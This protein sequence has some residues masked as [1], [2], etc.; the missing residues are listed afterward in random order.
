M[1]DTIV[2]FFQNPTL[3]G[4]MALIALGVFLIIRSN[5]K[6]NMSILQN[7]MELLKETQA[8][9]SCIVNM[10]EKNKT[11]E[12]RF[13]KVLAMYES[14]MTKVTATQDKIASTLEVLVSKQDE[15]SKGLQKLQVDLVRIQVNNKNNS[16]WGCE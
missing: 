4:L 2:A 12:D 13:D 6:N 8:N 15:C 9:Y 11:E 10:L 1:T 16:G 3:L 7:N 5:I 14:A